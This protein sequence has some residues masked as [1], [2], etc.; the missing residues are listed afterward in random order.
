MSYHTGAGN[1]MELEMGGEPAGNWVR[2]N[3]SPKL[4]NGLSLPSL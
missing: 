2:T 1:E 3:K 4:S